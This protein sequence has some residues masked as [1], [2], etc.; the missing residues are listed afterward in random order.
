VRAR[1]D[2][3]WRHEVGVDEVG[4]E[5]GEDLC[6]E[7]RFVRVVVVT[8]IRDGNRGGIASHW[9]GPDRDRVERVASEED[10]NGALGIVR[11]IE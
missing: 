3:A 8:I 5:L 7:D 10:G 2:H 1:I 6:D 4:V 9:H 11:H